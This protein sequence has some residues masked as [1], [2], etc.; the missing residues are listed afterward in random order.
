MS[1]N[2]MMKK[3]PELRRMK[4][5]TD[6]QLMRRLNNEELQNAVATPAFGRAASAEMRRRTKRRVARD[7]TA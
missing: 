2:V 5:L 1:R 3:E 6:G 7:A 4:M